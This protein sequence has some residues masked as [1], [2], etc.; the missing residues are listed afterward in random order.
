MMTALVAFTKVQHKKL[1]KR[2]GRSAKRIYVFPQYL[3]QG[4]AF[5]VVGLCYGD[6]VN[7]PEIAVF[8]TLNR[9][10]ANEYAKRL[11]DTTGLPCSPEDEDA[12]PYPCGL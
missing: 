11:A 6:W 9:R 2:N 7:H 1:P 5:Y 4:Q 8:V 3:A 10:E 12:P